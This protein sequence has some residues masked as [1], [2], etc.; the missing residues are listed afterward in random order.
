[1]SAYRSATAITLLVLLAVLGLTA[2]PIGLSSNGTFPCNS[3]HSSGSDDEVAFAGLALLLIP[4]LLRAF[5]FRKPISLT[6]WALVSVFVLTTVF[7]AFLAADCSDWL[8]TARV[9]GNLHL[10]AVMVLMALAMLVYLLP[11]RR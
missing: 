5:R 11:N 3:L 9:T 1:M 7:L 8:V 4:A 10:V 2:P 6:E